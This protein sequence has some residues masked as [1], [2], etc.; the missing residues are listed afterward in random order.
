MASGWAKLLGF[1]K[2]FSLVVWGRETLA[3]EPWAEALRVVDC[4]PRK[5]PTWP[6]TRR[7][8][9]NLKIILMLMAVVG[10]LAVAGCG[11]SDDDSTG[12]TSATTDTTATDT[13]A[14]DTTATDSD[15]SDYAQQLTSIL[16]DSLASLQSLSSIQSVKT[17]DE[18]SAKID[19]AQQQIQGTIDDLKALTP[20]EGAQEAQDQLIAAYENFNE[21]LGAVGDAVSS[22]DASAVTKA[23]AELTQ[24]GQDFQQEVT[25]AGQKFDAAGVQVGSGG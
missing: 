5:G 3:D 4:S 13:T 7:D 8:M 17:P 25:D 12:D 24:A 14:T 15:S 9:R 18:F 20:P 19:D 16:S 10:L 22:G 21:K 2:S 11:S 23:A 1:L 6:R